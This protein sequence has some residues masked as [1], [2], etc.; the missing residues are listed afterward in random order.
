MAAARPHPPRRP[1]KLVATL[2]LAAA[3]L[4]GGCGIN[5]AKRSYV[6]AESLW[7]DGKYAA[8]VAEFE[9]V[10]AKDPG[11]KL[12]LMALNRAATTQALFLNQYAE[13]VRKFRVFAEI[14]QDAEAAWEARR[15]IGEILFSKTENYE[16]AIAHYTQMLGLK[17][18]YPE[19]PEYLFR[20]GK[21][22]FYLRQFSEAVQTYRDL[23]Q[24]Y[25]GSHLAEKALFET[26]ITLYTR[27]GS[28]PRT[29]GSGPDY[30]QQAI[31]A[32]ERFL[33]VYPG[34][35]L[36][37]QARFGIANCLEEMDLLDQAFEA[38]LALRGKYPSPNVIEIKLARIK[39]RKSQRIR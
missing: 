21:S 34:S 30:Y 26:G 31:D 13:A 25:P 32:Y 1:S 27:G 10:I 19:A 22:Q 38:Y 20:I 3:L 28:S 18:Q 24:K 17:P 39:E 23:I 5:S 11:G 36:A 14:S 4:S 12:G 9:K 37:P 16:E 15:Q 2:A 35:E 33:K 29:R 6:M 7:T 8:A